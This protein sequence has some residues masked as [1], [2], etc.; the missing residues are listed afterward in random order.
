[1]TR[2]QTVGDFGSGSGTYVQQ[3]TGYKVYAR[4]RCRRR[5]FNKNIKIISQ[6]KVRYGGQLFIY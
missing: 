5:H 1:M 2:I 6:R 4:R 3:S